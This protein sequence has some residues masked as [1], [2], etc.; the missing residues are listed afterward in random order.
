[1]KL[2]KDCEFAIPP[3]ATR[4]WTCDHIS[5]LFKQVSPVTG[6]LQQDQ[7]SCNLWRT[8]GD[9]GKDAKFWKERKPVG[10]V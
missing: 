4:D 9:C 6:E 2:C 8:V 5:A 7:L 1:M 3:T 10:F